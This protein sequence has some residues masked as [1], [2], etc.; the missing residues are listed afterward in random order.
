MVKKIKEQKMSEKFEKKPAPKTA[1]ERIQALE[2]GMS[3]FAGQV[4]QLLNQ[5]QQALSQVSSLLVAVSNLLGP[6]KVTEEME[7]VR[8]AQL[9]ESAKRVQADIEAKLAEGKLLAQ[10]QVDEDSI[11]AFEET[12]DGVVS[13][14]GFASN[15]YRDFLP[16]FREM[17]LG[18]SVGSVVPVRQKAED[19]TGQDISAKVLGIYR[20]QKDLTPEAVPAN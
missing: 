1:L 12:V 18:A 11:V 13:P 14:P 19:G 17:F 20:E 5:H 3:T 9:G 16:E 8:L 7:R 6:E 15:H 10:D 2:D 4:S